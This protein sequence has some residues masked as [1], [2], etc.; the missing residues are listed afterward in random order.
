M[1]YTPIKRGGGCPRKYSHN[2]IVKIAGMVDNGKSYREIGAALGLPRK[3]A[4]Q[5]YRIRG[6]ETK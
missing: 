5:L 2:V 6:N 4:Y 1:I 3:V